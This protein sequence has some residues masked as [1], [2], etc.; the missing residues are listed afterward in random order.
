MSRKA[1][2]GAT[3]AERLAHYSKPGKNGCRVWTGYIDCV[4][5]GRLQFEGFYQ[6]SHRIA[7]RLANNAAIP[8]GMKVLHRCDNRTCINPDHLFLGTQAE[9]MTDMILKG[10]N[11][12]KI[13]PD[14]V[15]QIMKTSG[16]NA[17][18]GRKFGLATSG[19]WRIKNGRG[20][21]HITGL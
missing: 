4:G 6:K 15:R 14:Q 3:T 18:I 1:F 9:N 11:Y 13:T 19:I 2:R 8:K 12:S 17:E 10:R 21:R 5:Y 7:W 16:T 20:W